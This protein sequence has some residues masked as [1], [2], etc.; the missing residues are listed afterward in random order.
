LYSFA[1]KTIQIFVDFSSF[2][3]YY[4]G[5]E[6]LTVKEVAKELE[7]TVWRVHQLIKGNRLP[8]E[9]LGSQY[10]VKKQDLELVKNRTPGRP[11]KT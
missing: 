11:K 5:V 10:V 2:F 8:A 6:L 7:I 4:F 3:C 9:K 1:S